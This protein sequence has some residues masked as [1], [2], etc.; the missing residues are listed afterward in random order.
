MDT[1]YPARL[2]GELDPAVGRWLWLVKSSRAAPVERS[3]SPF[4]L[5]I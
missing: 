1:P 3:P 4:R 5:V 2:D